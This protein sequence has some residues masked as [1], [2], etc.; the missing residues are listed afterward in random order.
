MISWGLQQVGC[1]SKMKGNRE[2][3]ERLW[4]IWGE[5]KKE[6]SLCQRKVKTNLYKEEGN[7][8]IHKRQ[9]ERVS[10][11]RIL[12]CN[13]F[14]H[15]FWGSKLFC[16]FC[17]LHNQPD[18]C[19]LKWNEYQLSEGKLCIIQRVTMTVSYSQSSRKKILML[20]RFVQS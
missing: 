10:S 11:N 3:F 2:L 18:Y 8:G 6:L 15:K 13:I 19:I 20:T 1:Q 12:V 14:F 7:F 9:T 17:L 16:K 5:E 4:L